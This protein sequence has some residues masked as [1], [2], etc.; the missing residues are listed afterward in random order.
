ML[1]QSS[2]HAQKDNIL[3]STCPSFTKIMSIS[4]KQLKGLYAIMH[5]AIL[6]AS[7]DANFF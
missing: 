7:C 4:L 5:A 6:H 1:M 3:Y 2:T